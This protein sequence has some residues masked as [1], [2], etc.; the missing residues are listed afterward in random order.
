MK[1]NL[2][3]ELESEKDEFYSD[4][5]IFNFT[6]WGADLSFRELIQRYQDD[7]LIKP[8]MQRN[9]VWDKVEAS[10]FVESLLLGLPVPSIFLAKTEDEK[11]LIVDG[12]QRIMTV[13]D[14]VRGISNI[15]GK[16]FKLT[17]SAKINK[18][19]RGKAF[20]ELSDIDQ[21]RIRNTT[22]HAIIFS[23]RKPA[24]SDTGMYQIFERINTSGRTLLP[25]EIRN[26]VYQNTKMNRLLLELNNNA[27]WRNLFGSP[28]PDSRMRDIEFILRFFALKQVYIEQ[29]DSTSISLKRT[30][31]VYMGSPENNTPEKIEKLR[32]KFITTITQIYE[33]IG[34]Q[35]FHNMSEK[36]QVLIPKFHPTVY[37]S[38]MIAVAT[39]EEG[40]SLSELKSNQHKILSAPEYQDLLRFRTTNIENIIKRVDFV[41]EFMKGT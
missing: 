8:E 3:V 1:K 34:S 12:Y 16:T 15:D 36:K 38:I 11:L 18:R 20:S 28:T 29:P 39:K 5:D 27:I 23:Q 9:Y 40:M 25:Q 33:V 22:I 24:N 32:N 4:D 37:D 13:Y 2:V 6:S 19:W 30:L 41:K 35:A 14:Y 31:N 26:C 10:R 7:E 21:R 17:D